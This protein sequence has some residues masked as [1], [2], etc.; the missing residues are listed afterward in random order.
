MCKV[1][2]STAEVNM[3]KVFVCDGCRMSASPD[4]IPKSPALRDSEVC[5]LPS[6]CFFV[7]GGEVR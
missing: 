1:Y 4:R 7:F 6:F 2:K 3:D 5:F